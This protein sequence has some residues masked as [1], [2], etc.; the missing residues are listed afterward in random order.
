M[1]QFDNNNQF[2]LAICRHRCV[3]C[4]YNNNHSQNAIAEYVFMLT[5]NK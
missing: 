3:L 4:I 5:R 1:N 2:Q